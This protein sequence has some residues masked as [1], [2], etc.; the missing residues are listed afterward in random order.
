MKPFNPRRG[1]RIRLLFGDPINC[2][3]EWCSE[4]A[5]QRTG[6]EATRAALWDA[7]TTEMHSRMAHLER[8]LHPSFATTT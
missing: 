5:Q 4:T 7:L 2:D 8:R 6:K 1:Q 3:A